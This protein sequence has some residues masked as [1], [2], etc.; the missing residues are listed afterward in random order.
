MTLLTAKQV[1]H[2]LQVTT[3]RVYEMSRL[4]LLPVVRMGR[5]VRFEEGALQSW[6]AQG[7]TASSWSTEFYNQGETT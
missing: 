5:Q 4:R 3:A 7:G 1:A 6:I 2:I